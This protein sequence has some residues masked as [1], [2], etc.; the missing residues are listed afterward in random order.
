MQTRNNYAIQADNA[1]KLFLGYDQEKIIMAF[2][3]RHDGAYLYLN[4]IHTPY[5]ICRKTGQVQRLA[6]NEWLDGAFHEVLSVYDMLCNPLG[7][8]ALSGAWSPVGNLGRVHS[9]SAPVGSDSFD[10]Y[11]LYF[12]GKQA[13]LKRACEALGGAPAPMGDV[14]YFLPLFDFFPVYLRFYDADE[15]LP[16][17]LQILWDQN[18]CRY[19]RYETTFYATIVLLEKIK[20][21]VEK[22]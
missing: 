4:F 1:R 20:A 9:A 12:S 8:P 6:G 7:L 2:S 5:R 21:L 15:E 10:S 18:T 17:Q 14:A 11:G 3:L 13:A 19:F 22:M 16:A